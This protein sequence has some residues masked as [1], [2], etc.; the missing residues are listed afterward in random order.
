MTLAQV[1]QLADEVKLTALLSKLLPTAAQQYLQNDSFWQQTDEKQQRVNLLSALSANTAR[2]LCEHLQT[3]ALAQAQTKAVEAAEAAKRAAQ[4]EAAW[5]VLAV[6]ATAQKDARIDAL[7]DRAEDTRYALQ[8]LI[9]ERKAG[10]QPIKVDDLVDVMR[11]F[12][13]FLF[14]AHPRSR[15]RSRVRTRDRSRSPAR[16]D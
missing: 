3:A 4:E 11:P 1:V 9:N 7:R 6:K 8:T 16:R 10:R 12:D 2:L 15:S 14:P 13:V 5:A